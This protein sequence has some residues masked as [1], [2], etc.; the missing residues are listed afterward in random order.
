MIPA[1]FSWSDIGEW[2]SIYQQKSSIKDDIVSLNQTTKFVEVGSRH[3]LVSGLSHKLIGLVD[4]NNLAIID[5]P[6]ALLICNIA[7]NGSYKVRD[8]ISKIV[9][10][11]KLKHY[12][13]SSNDH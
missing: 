7:Q 1:S 12:F 10:D 5:T 2:K 11:P 6:D 4:V 13:L 9:E 8:L 3:C